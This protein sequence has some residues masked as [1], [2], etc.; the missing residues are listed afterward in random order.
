[1]SLRYPREQILDNA[2]GN[3]IRTRQGEEGHGTAA[4]LPLLGILG[5]RRRDSN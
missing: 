3:L 1:M 2:A 5:V 4:S